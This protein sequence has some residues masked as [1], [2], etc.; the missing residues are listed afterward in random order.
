MT[1]AEEFGKKAVGHITAL[2][3]SSTGA[4]MPPAQKAGLL[5]AVH[6]TLGRVYL[7]QKR[8]GEAERA[9]LAALAA[10]K[11][12]ENAYLML[13]LALA[14]QVPPRINEAMESWAKAAYLKGRVEPQAREYLQAFYM[15]EKKS[16]EGLELFIQVVGAGIDQ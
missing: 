9:Y 12:D 13:G 14:R 3:S 2:I 10:R 16:L 4:S 1:R 8:Y 15:Q 5:S 11:D 6:T 7:N